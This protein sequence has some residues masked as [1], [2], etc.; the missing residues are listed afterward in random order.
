MKRQ[1]KEFL[2]KTF[3]LQSNYLKYSINR[4]STNLF[5]QHNV[6]VTTFGFFNN[7]LLKH[8]GSVHLNLTRMDNAFLL[9]LI[10]L[11]ILSNLCILPETN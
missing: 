11:I 10:N 4:Y 2:S 6:R 7:M 9:L 3:L 1:R 8:S 5:V